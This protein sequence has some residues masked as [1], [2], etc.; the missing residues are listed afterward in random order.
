[1]KP[2]IM[3]K[4]K[5]RLLLSCPF[6]G[7][8]VC[9]RKFVENEAVGTAC[10]N[11]DGTISY[12]PSF[13]NALTVE[14]CVFVIAHEAM[15]VVYA[16]LPRMGDRNPRVWNI[17][18]DAVIND[19]LRVCHVGTAPKGSVMIEG[20]RHE[21]AEAL[22]NKLMKEA[23]N[24]PSASDSESSSDGSDG[25]V[26]LPK[27]GE[28]VEDLTTEQASQCSEADAK[29]QTQAG[30]QELASTTVMC[31]QAG[32]LPHAVAQ[33]VEG[34]LES[35][36]PWHQV[37]ERFMTSKSE[38]RISW[39]RP[40][41]RFADVYMPRRARMPSMG[42]IVIGVD[43]SGS[44]G[45]NEMRSFFGHIQGILD[46]CNPEEVIILYAT[47][48]IEEV[49]RHTRDDYPL[50]PSHNIWRGGTD[51]RAVTEWISA[52]DEEVECAV[53]LT[54]G[55]TPFPKES[56]CDLVWVITEGGAK[57]SGVLGD[58]IYM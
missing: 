14:E 3:Q 16:H 29:T 33:V 34:L 17:A 5:V 30:L 31:R 41:K 2:S 21:T 25:E 35:K 45:D 18:T 44:I 7:A 50:T 8:I 53:I 39:S 38:K 37:L 27:Y 6:F 58:V 42:K 9:K 24:N 10:V 49:E 51:M 28:I 32:N 52:Q 15:H 13:V 57:C 22:Y 55:Y 1:M 43:T 36:V 12:A 47:T 40:N 23:E 20:A 48:E 19:L 26:L 46:Q 54:D 11:K 56:P 4:A